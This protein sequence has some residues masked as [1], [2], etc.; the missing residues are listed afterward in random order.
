MFERLHLTSGESAGDGLRRSGLD[1]EVL[2]W[3]DLLYDGVRTPGWPDQGAL[4]ARSAFLSR[5]TGG[6]LAAGRILESLAAQYRRLDD[7]CRANR[8]VLWFDACLFDQAMLVHVLACLRQRDVRHVDLIVID[9]FPGIV[10]FHGLGQLAPEQLASL[11]GLRVPVTDAQFR[12]ADVVEHAFAA[13]DADLLREIAR[14]TNAPLPHVPAAAAR[15]L[16]ECP[17][18]DSG[19]GRLERL[20]IEAV[21]DG[22]TTPSAIYRW[23]ADADT[24]PQYW[25]DATLWAVLNRLAERRPARLAIAGPVPRLPQFAGVGPSLDSFRITIAT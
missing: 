3:R 5:A 8:I 21:R 4:A 25:G 16:E 15:W 7:A 18:A 12:F 24:P 2:V 23:V 14:T 20:A 19:L 17:D 11:F 22:C 10:P 6:A 9:R 13:Q 1:G